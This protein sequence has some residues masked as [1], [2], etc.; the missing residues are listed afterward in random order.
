ME[1][2]SKGGCMR[3][4]WLALALCVSTLTLTEKMFAVEKNRDWQTGQVVEAKARADSR[5]HAIA[6]KDKTYLVR[7]SIGGDDDVLAV[8]AA[9]RYA[10]QGTTMYLSI[11]GNE[12]HLAV[13]GTTVRTA[14]PT[15]A[16]SP[17]VTP[18]QGV[19]K[20]QRES[21]SPPPSA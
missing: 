11:A 4:A 5:V 2:V 14:P 6:G 20:A 15:P 16:A 13:L 21:A 17:A 10:V 9:V 19:T 18:V 8:G 12:Y 1:S 7:G 3:N